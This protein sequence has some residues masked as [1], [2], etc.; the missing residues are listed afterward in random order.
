MNID[1]ELEFHLNMSYKDED[2]VMS[3]LFEFLQKHLNIHVIK[4]KRF[5]NKADVDEIT[6]K[7]FY[8]RGFIRAVLKERGRLFHKDLHFRFE[9]DKIEVYTNLEVGMYGNI[10]LSEKGITEIIRVM[11]DFTTKF[12]RNIKE[13]LDDENPSRK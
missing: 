12:N 4:W 11:N 13:C 6:G 9:N 3:P 8:K 5:V 2:I 10:N 7:T 1:R